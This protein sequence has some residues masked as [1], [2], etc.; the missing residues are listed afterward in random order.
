MSWPSFRQNTWNNPPVVYAPERLDPNHVAKLRLG[1]IIWGTPIIDGQGNVYVG[2]TNKRFFCI[3]GREW[4]MKWSYKIDNKADAL[5]DSAAALHPSG[6]VVVPGG[7]GCLHAL[8]AANGTVAWK[9]CNTD[10]VSEA[11]HEK[12]VIVN[13]FEGNVQIDQEG[14]VYAGCDNEYMY[15]LSPEGQLKWKF[16]TRMMIW[17]CAVVVGNYCFFGSLD[18]YLYCVNR[19]TGNLVFK[20]NTGS[21]IKSSPLF[22]A[23]K[24]YVGNTNGNVYCFDGDRVVWKSDVTSIYASPIVHEDGIVFATFDGDIVKFDLATGRKIWTQ[25]THSNICCSPVIVNGVVYVGNNKGMLFAIDAAKGGF[26]GAKK[27]SGEMHKNSINAS[28]SCTRDGY[29]ILGSYDGNIYRVPWNF[30]DVHNDVSFRAL[31]GIDHLRTHLRVV[32]EGHIITMEL[33]VPAR[34]NACLSYGSVRLAKD[35]P[36]DSYI[37]ADGRYLNLVPKDWSYLN[38][39]FTVQISGRYYLQTDSWMKDRFVS[40][41]Y[42]FRDVVT[43]RTSTPRNISMPKSLQLASFYVQ[44]P[45]VFDTYIPAAMDAQGFKVYLEGDANKNKN[46]D[47]KMIPCI[48]DEDGHFEE[49]EKGVV[50]KLKGERV[51]NIIKAQGGFNI[52]AMGGTLKAKKM[53]AFFDVTEE[54]KVDGQL[55][56]MTNPMYLKGNGTSYKF[57]SEIVN[58]ICDLCLNI[59]V[60][61]EYKG[62][63]VA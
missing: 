3:D 46:I 59:N 57:S 4:T 50:I 62:T 49:L 34:K 33:V 29:I 10:D 22:H 13:S 1:G 52:S 26:L 41:E 47:I 15:C 40:R 37:S 63:V 32:N 56:M 43:F 61:A 16:R 30:F 48:P 60:V 12:G 39:Q 54:G 8:D 19:H 45:T 7:D 42:I 51:G 55:F 21:E 24:L 36:F 28:I 11:M 17:T 5:I 38:K 6:L 44:Q 18:F 25:E 2:S 35:I 58:K 53:I 27:V 23:G 20:H 31:T 14:N 9:K